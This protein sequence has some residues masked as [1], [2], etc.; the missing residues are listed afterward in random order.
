[1]CTKIYH[2]NTNQKKTKGTI[3]ISNKVHLEL[4][5]SP[6][7]KKN[8]IILLAKDNSRKHYNPMFRQIVLT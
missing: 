2:V 5:I 4:E 7:I 6:E 8:I 3:F 1:M